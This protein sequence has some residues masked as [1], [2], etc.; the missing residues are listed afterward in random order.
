M[1]LRPTTALREPANYGL[2]GWI[3]K[4]SSDLPRYS[5]RYSR[6]AVCG[7]DRAA[8]PAVRRRCFGDLSRERERHED[9][10]GPDGPAVAGICGGGH[11]PGC[12]RYGIGR[13][14]AA[15]AVGMDPAGI[16]LAGDGLHHLVP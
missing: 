2:R 15:R 6:A 12:R 13:I 5:V 7:A 16:G 10:E 1:A 3:S 11:G 8:F 14:G 9:V 4:R